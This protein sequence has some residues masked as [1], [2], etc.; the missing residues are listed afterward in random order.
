MGTGLAG[1]FQK[2]GND[3][4]IGFPIEA[5]LTNAAVLPISSLSA[6]TMAR[7]PAPAVRRMVPSMSKRIS[8]LTGPP[9]F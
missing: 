9:A 8:F 4:G 3:L 2:F 7:R 1:D 5:H 6:A